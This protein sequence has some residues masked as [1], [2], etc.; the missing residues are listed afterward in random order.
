ML[1]EHVFF[2]FSITSEHLESISLREVRAEGDFL[3][4]KEMVNLLQEEKKGTRTTMRRKDVSLSEP[5]LVSLLNF[6][7]KINKSFC[8]TWEQNYAH[9]SA[10][11]LDSLYLKCKRHSEQKLQTLSTH[12]FPMRDPILGRTPRIAR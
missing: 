5:T 3:Q 10:F 4:L 6:M 8:V 12:T 7:T 2:F 9:K 1:Q 11:K